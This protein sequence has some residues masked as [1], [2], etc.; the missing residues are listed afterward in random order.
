MAE[1]VLLLVPEWHRYR[2]EWQQLLPKCVIFGSF[3]DRDSLQIAA[4]LAR[5][6]PLNQRVIPDQTRCSFEIHPIFLVFFPISRKLLINLQCKQQLE[7]ILLNLPPEEIVSKKITELQERTIEILRIEEQRGQIQQL[8]NNQE[9]ITPE[10]R[11]CRRFGPITA[12]Y[13]MEMMYFPKIYLRDQIYNGVPLNYDVET[14]CDRL[15]LPELLV[16]PDVN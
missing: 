3:T 4:K 14:F 9:Q 15:I 11:A 6:Y 1:L 5:Y 10:E 2:K 13:L 12:R 16:C 7:S 8:W